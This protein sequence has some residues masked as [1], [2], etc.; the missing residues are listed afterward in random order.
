MNCCGHCGCVK[1]AALALTVFSGCKSHSGGGCGC[2]GGGARTTAMPMPAPRPMAAPMPMAAPRP[3]AGAYNAICP[4]MGEPID[5]SVPTS[6]YNGKTVGFCCTACKPR[7][8]ANPALY[9]SKL[10]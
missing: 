1:L 6:V 3:M 8:D 7:F 10:P 4:V 5:P 2:G 9:A